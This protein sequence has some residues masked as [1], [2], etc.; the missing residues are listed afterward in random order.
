MVRRP[1]S[2]KRK[3]AKARGDRVIVLLVLLFIIAGGIIFRLFTV[4]I[5]AADHYQALAQ[6]QHELYAELIPERGNIIV[7]DSSSPSGTFTLAANKE[8]FIV[9]AVPREVEN[10]DR[11]ARELKDIVQLEE[12]EIRQAI[13]D[14]EN[15]PYQPIKKHLDK[16]QADRVRDLELSGIRLQPESVRFYPNDSLTSHVIGYVGYMADDNF[17]GVT[18]LE[19]YYEEE[20]AGERGQLMAEKDARGQWLPVGDRTLQ[21][22]VDG[23]TLVLTIDR[24]IQ[25]HVEEALRETI[26]KHSAESGSV[27]VMDPKTGEIIALANYPDFNPNEYGEVEDVSVFNNRAIFDLYEPGSTF[28]VIQVAAGIESGKISPGTTFD[29]PGSLSIGSYTIYN[30]ENKSYG[31][32][33]V[34]EAIENSDNVVLAKIAQTTGPDIISDYFDKFGFRE[35]TGIDIAKESENYIKPADEWKEIDVATSGF[36]QGLTV[37]PI[38]LITAISAF[39][40]NGKIMRPHIVQA[41]ESPDGEVQEIKP[42]FVRQAVTG[43]TALTMSSIMRSAV[44]NGFASPADIEGYEIAGKTGTAQVAAEGKKGYDENKKI[45]SF[46]GFPVDNPVFI[47]LVKID[48]AK[49]DY[50]AGA[51]VAAPLFKDIAEFIFENQGIPPN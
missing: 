21:E 16:G 26:E 18:G 45:V 12:D 4:Q 47:M 51:T 39:A 48:N 38:Q 25:F 36:G 34:T 23:D 15:D 33:T 24:T 7:Q 20:L 46:V 22:A 19:N 43:K 49:G 17:G 10:K 40:N 30:Y 14:D 31:T 9:Y 32:M 8:L 11:V 50:V 1:R 5:M 35:L 3:Q 37:S 44:A 29:D 42:E 41:I 28:K 6:D 27:V 13:G 2:L